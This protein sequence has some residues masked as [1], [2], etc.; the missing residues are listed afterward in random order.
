MYTRGTRR[1]GGWGRLFRSGCGV[2]VVCLLSVMLS[3]VSWAQEPPPTLPVTTLVNTAGTIQV[4][5]A[6]T[7]AD[8]NHQNGWGG[9]VV[10]L[11]HR[12]S[13]SGN[14][15]PNLVR[16][17]AGGYLLQTAV[18]HGPLS[19]Y[20]RSVTPLPPDSPYW[21][22]DYDPLPWPWN[23]T[24]GG[25]YIDGTGA[26]QYWVAGQFITDFRMVNGC[27]T[28]TSTSPPETTCTIFS[29]DYL[30][31]YVAPMYGVEVRMSL[32]NG[33]RGRLWYIT[34][35]DRTWN[36]GKSIAFDITGLNNFYT[37]NLTLDTTPGWTGSPVKQ[38]MFVPTN[39]ATATDGIK[40]DYLKATPTGASWEFDGVLRGS[41]AYIVG[42]GTSPVPW[43]HTRTIPW[44]WRYDPAT[45]DDCLVLDQTTYVYPDYVAI[46]Y[47]I[48]TNGQQ[49]CD[50]PAGMHESPVL[51]GNPTALETF[52][53]Y[54]GSSPW[55][56]L[57]PSVPT[58]TNKGYQVFPTEGW[59]GAYDSTTGLGVTFAR[60]DWNR[61][62]PFSHHWSFASSPWSQV[63]RS[64]HYV[65]FNHSASETISW[66]VYFIPG[67]VAEGRKIA[68]GLLPHRTWEFEI[69]GATEGWTVG[70][71]LTNLRT[72]DHCLKCTS[73][74]N[75]P[76][77][78]SLDQLDF[79]SDSGQALQFSMAVTAGVTGRVYYITEE[80]QTWNEAKARWFLVKPNSNGSTYYTYTIR[81]DDITGW[82]GKAVKRLRLVPTSV[83]T[84][85]DGI[86]IK[87]IRLLSNSGDW[88]FDCA[89]NTEGWTAGQYLTNFRAQ[90]GYLYGTST[91]PPETTCTMY[92][93]DHISAATA[94]IGG[95]EVRMYIK[96]GTRGRLWYITEAD[97]TWNFD[98]SVAFDITGLNQ[99][100]T[101]K[102]QLNN[103]A[104]W[105]G[106]PVR[107]LL[108]VPTNTSTVTDGIRIAY[109]KLLPATSWEFNGTGNDEGWLPVTS[110][111]RDRA[112]STTGNASVSG[113][114]YTLDSVGKILDINTIDGS[115]NHV[116]D[117]PALQSPFPL[118]VPVASFS[119]Y[120]VD[121][122]MK[123]T[124]T[125]P[126]N[127]RLRYTL[128]NDLK[129]VDY[130]GMGTVAMFP[131][132]GNGYPRYMTVTRFDVGAHGDLWANSLTANQWITVSFNLPSLSYPIDQFELVPTDKAGTVEIDS[133]AVHDI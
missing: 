5:I 66:W 14:W 91:S 128:T 17:D 21:I 1:R 129:V 80:D 71:E 75:N 96:N 70:A 15:G 99:F 69:D 131:Q 50:H 31:P 77:I 8:V 132:D 76:Y 51:Y 24:Q 30:S 120:R 11:C 116:Y 110:R 87:Y 111:L 97:G 82:S 98:K 54:D 115:G 37:Y 18:Y 100:Y 55:Q 68:Y 126:F 53:L 107:Q 83:P 102:L 28:G 57:S 9:A 90:N 125:G 46:N 2:I 123:F 103:T 43:C 105:T 61:H 127:A 48:S 106:S 117:Y 45:L 89:D 12:P 52:E 4:G 113:G 42:Q 74:G 19:N 93:A 86:K 121:V 104:G 63:L 62:Q 95:A 79:S 72:E 47:A 81:L 122:R 112:W 59:I 33:T 88:E 20:Y 118:N 6:T 38:L 119:H 109:L 13:G 25:D 34:E 65:D 29:P 60:P 78:R 64:R 85:T 39:T 16:G 35:A 3:G 114:I 49:T 22:A 101:Y 56:N 7:G 10:R 108:F 94:P 124:G 40:I 130:H 84:V 73:T 41:P 26:T 36:L 32:S 58:Q 133:I 92:S 44:N 27:L 67:T 23:P